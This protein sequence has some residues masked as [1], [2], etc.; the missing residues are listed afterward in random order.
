MKSDLYLSVYQ[1]WQ[2]NAAFDYANVALLTLGDDT[3]RIV[4]E[5]GTLISHGG[6]ND[7][8]K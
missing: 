5:D 4:K 8:I 6:F 3:K 1:L 2:M 7:S